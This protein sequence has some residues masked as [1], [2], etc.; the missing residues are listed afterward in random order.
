VRKEI[1]IRLSCRQV[2]GGVQAKEIGR[3]A[4]V[5]V[6]VRAIESGTKRVHA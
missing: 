6:L 4:R 3:G 1:C 5:G 2:V